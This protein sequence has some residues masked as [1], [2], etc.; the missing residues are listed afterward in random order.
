MLAV[1]SL[2]TYG[3]LLVVSCA[4]SKYA[5]LG[6]LRSTS[7]LTSYELVLSS[8]ILL[9]SGIFL[10]PIGLRFPPKP[11]GGIAKPGNIPEDIDWDDLLGTDIIP[12]WLY[13]LLWLFI[14]R[15]IINKL[16]PVE[17]DIRFKKGGVH[18][19]PN[20]VWHYGYC[21]Y[22]AFYPTCYW[23]SWLFYGRDFY[24]SDISINGIHTKCWVF[25][26]SFGLM[27]NKPY[28]NIQYGWPLGIVLTVPTPDRYLGG[29]MYTIGFSIRTSGYPLKCSISYSGSQG[30]GGIW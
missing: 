26:D 23:L 18:R 12:S 22:D 2:S 28:Y 6:A 20:G 13:W 30:G 14:F 7:Q 15:Q 27:L 19:A 16:I 24:F 1:S 4:N 29:F 5:F 8:A 11:I 25:Q 9:L 17:I 21:I 10:P 3:I